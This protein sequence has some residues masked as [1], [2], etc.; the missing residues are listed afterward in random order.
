MYF[1]NADNADTEAEIYNLSGTKI[2]SAQIINNS[3]DLRDINAGFYLIRTNK[4]NFSK[5]IKQ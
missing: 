4:T 5:F 3:I 1:T 2:K